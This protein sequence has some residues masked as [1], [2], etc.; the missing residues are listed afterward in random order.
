MNAGVIVEVVI[1]AIS[2]GIAPAITLEQIFKNRGRIDPIRERD[3]H[4]L[5]PRM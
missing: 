5:L 4:L 3:L 2:P 1:D